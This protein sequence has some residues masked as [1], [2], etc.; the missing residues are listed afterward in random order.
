MVSLGPDNSDPTNYIN[1]NFISTVVEGYSFIATQGP[2]TT[3]VANFWKMIWQYDVS[4]IM[5]FC[6]LE[7][8]NKIKCYKYW[9]SKDHEGGIL[10]LGEG[11]KVEFIEDK[12][13]KEHL[14]LRKFRLTRNGKAKEVVQYHVVLW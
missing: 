7:E 2:L 12:D 6:N 10:S 13:I 3:T 14:V 1:A 5:M 4:I 9:P 11:F 8:K